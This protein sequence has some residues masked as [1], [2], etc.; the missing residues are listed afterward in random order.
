MRYRVTCL[1]PTLIG[2]GSRLSPID[3]MVWKDQVNVLNQ[4]RIFRVLAKGPRLDNYLKQIKR[5]DKLD[6]ASWGGFAQNFALRRIQFEHAPSTKYWERLSAEHLHIPTFVSGTGGPF[7]PASA[8]KGALR[9]GLVAARV[10]RTITKG[11]AEGTETNRPPRNPGQAAEERAVGAPSHDRLKVIAPA[12]SDPAPGD[13]L[14]IYLV[15]TAALKPRGAGNYELRWKVSPSGS[16]D[17]NRPEAS[18][19]LFAEM[20]APGTVFEGTWTEREFYRDPQIVKALRWK[21]PLATAEILRAAN[22]HAATVLQLHREYARWASLARLHA[23]LEQLE[24]RLM[25]IRDRKDAC[26][27][28]LGWGGGFVTKSASPNTSEESYRQLLKLYPFYSQ[29]IRSGLPFPKTRRIVFL[30]DRPAAL[31]GWVLLETLAKP[32]AT[33]AS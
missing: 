23:S 9:T 24:H 32:A 30:E 11:A 15:R 31:P 26:L 6:F 22:D 2:D 20:A 29:A 17:A 28:P 33:T 18:T 12:D 25:E 10:G 4:G 13:A 1:T 27:L 7:L 8:L 14:K 3:Y 5:A 19:P 16:A 21:A